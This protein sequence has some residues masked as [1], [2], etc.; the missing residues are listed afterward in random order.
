MKYVEKLDGYFFYIGRA[1]GQVWGGYSSPTTSEIVKHDGTTETSF[2]MKYR[3]EY[4][5]TD[6]WLFRNINTV[7]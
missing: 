5:M 6:F 3:T 1:S 7:Y 4:E 2:D